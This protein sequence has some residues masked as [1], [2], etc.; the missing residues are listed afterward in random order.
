MI[1]LVETT[2]SC[3]NK[4]T[5]DLQMDPLNIPNR[6]RDFNQTTVQALLSFGYSEDKVFDVM[7]YMK[8]Q[9]KSSVGEIDR[10]LDL[11]IKA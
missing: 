4:L 8:Q 11:L 2:E 1:R 3:I 10:A 9:N 5:K 6:F 7:K